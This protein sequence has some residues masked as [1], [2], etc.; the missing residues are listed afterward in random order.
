MYHFCRD[1]CLSRQ[2]TSFV[3]TKACLPRQ[4]LCRNKHIFVATN[5]HNFIATNVLSR[6]EY[7]FVDKT[8][9]ATKMI[10]AAAPVNDS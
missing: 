8:F 9:V 4:N 2:N 3:A 7:A 10:L 6:Q 5:K 1:K